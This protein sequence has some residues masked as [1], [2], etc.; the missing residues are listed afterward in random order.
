MKNGEMNMDK[1]KETQYIQNDS[2]RISTSSKGDYLT[3]RMNST[4]RQ[5]QNFQRSAA[6]T[7]NLGRQVIAE[8]LGMHVYNSVILQQEKSILH[9]LL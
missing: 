2:K 6:A 9:K 5:K 4:I 1:G 8:R 7:W 3:T